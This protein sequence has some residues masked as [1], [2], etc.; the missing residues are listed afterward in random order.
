V[1][2]SRL[3]RATATLAERFAVTAIAARGSELESELPFGVARQLLGAA[4]LA[5][6]PGGPSETESAAPVPP[7]RGLALVEQLHN[8]LLDM[9]FPVGG[10]SPAPLVM[11][12]DDAQWADR[13]SLRF[14]AHL[15]ARIDD[16]PIALVVAVRTGEQGVPA[17]LLHALHATAGQV[18]RPA[19]LSTAAVDVVVRSACGDVGE[20]VVRACASASGGNPFYLG[21]LV[22][23]L[24]AAGPAPSVEAVADAAPDGVLRA[25]LVR[26]AKLGAQPTALAKAAAVL[27]DGTPLELV[28]EFAG[29]SL[30]EAEDA[31]DAL[32]AAGL[33]DH[34]EPIRFAHPLINSTLRADLGAFARARAHY[35]AAQ[36]LVRA[37]APT[38]QIA[39]HL[40]RSRPQ[41]DPYSVERLRAAAAV[42][43]SRGEPQA[44]VHLLERALVEPPP[45]QA[46]AAVLLELAESD[47]LCGSPLAVTHL[48]RA[49]EL[50]VDP[51]QRA[52]ALNTLAGLIH[53]TGDYG[54]A[55]ELAL[56]G[57]RELP[58]G[59]PLE[60][61]LRATLIGSALLHPPL[62]A[63]LP[64]LLDPLIE[65]AQQGS[66]PTAPGLL[67]VLAMHFSATNAPADLVRR[68][69]VAA[70]AADPLVDP[71][72]QGGAL[73]F[74][75]A[76]LV[77][78][79]ALDALEP[80]VD[81]A[82][83]TAQRRGAQLTGSIAGHYR[84]MVNYHR[85]RLAE[86]VADAERSWQTYREGWALSSW[87]TPLLALAHLE[88]GDLPAAAEAIALGERG[89]PSRAEH[90]VLLEARAAY[91]LASG[92]PAGARADA[93]A[94]AAHLQ[95]DYGFVPCR[96]F[97][98]RRLA[99]LAAHRLGDQAEAQRLLDAALAELRSVEAP[100]QL[101]LNLTAAGVIAGGAAGRTLL[102]EAV[103]VL[104]HSPAQL[105]YAHALRALGAAHHETGDAAAAKDLLYRALELADRFSA[106]PLVLRTRDDLRA[107]G[108]RP[109]RTARTGAAALTPSERRV[110]D[111]AADGLS[112]P[113]IA[114]Q[115]HLTRKTVESHLA[116]VYRKLG[117]PGRDELKTAL[118]PE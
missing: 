110:A 87:S 2:K 10:G 106:V 82:M 43:R 4:M 109:R 108:L 73:G 53:H 6:V 93:R 47:A 88:R 50:M 55:A 64:A 37:G 111:L 62:R 70:F 115:L 100:R 74:A 69:A 16:L 94:A 29:L 20:D 24:A 79:D 117:I 35:R 40:L 22:R 28:A 90:A 12:V 18:L 25:L 118:S 54:R 39:Q 45:R 114:H 26:L 65:A 99:G 27:G 83:H 15:A 14:L 89:D 78:V 38:E 77:D 17:E 80:L 68:L 34:G 104:E 95:G 48:E 36:L 96:G 30:T 44:A 8:T 33:L 76:A 59:H 3:L 21:E 98:W 92:D 107:L 85:G 5:A 97:D 52:R 23:E 49:I 13:P 51:V 81:T 67:A 32:A 102:T 116:H 11:L 60:Q 41:A 105:H 31:A 19:P 58:A 9:V 1:G 61:S 86:A 63:A 42:A 101:G 84:A 46:R 112:N 7:D 113:Q 103:A 71:D 91:R 57:Q 75:A 56:R 66:F 72:S